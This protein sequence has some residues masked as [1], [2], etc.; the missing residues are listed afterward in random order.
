MIIID[1]TLIKLLLKNIKGINKIARLCNEIAKNHGWKTTN[2][3]DFKHGIHKIPAKLMLVITEVSEACE[4]YRN[5]D[6]NN[7]VEELADIVIRVFV[8]NAGLDLDLEEALKNKILKN[9]KREFKHGNK[10]E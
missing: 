6:I 3:K 8:I 5:N 1:E 4:A 2:I 9:N 7:F 10:K